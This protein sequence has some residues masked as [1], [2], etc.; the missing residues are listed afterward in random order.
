MN[1][2][3]VEITVG[4]DGSPSAHRALTWAVE[5]AVR[6]HL[7]VHIVT[8]W[9]L[10]IVYAGFSSAVAVPMSVPLVRAHGEAAVARALQEAHAAGA[11]ARSTFCE[12]DAGATLVRLSAGADQVVV[13]DRGQSPV[14]RSLM[15]S[16]SSYVAHHSDVPVTVV[17]GDTRDR[18]PVIVGVDP[19]SPSPPAI[20]RAAIEAAMSEAE[21]LVIAT[22]TFADSGRVG[23]LLGTEE[24]TGEGIERAVREQVS[25]LITDVISTLGP[26]RTRLDVAQGA[27]RKVLVRA[28][29]GADLLVVGTR[30]LGAVGRLCLGSTSTSCL[31]H[32]ACPVQVVP[33]TGH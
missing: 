30:R 32:A 33:P 11:Q 18:R 28:S 17:R 29:A 27:A 15:G 2:E 12:A 5:R 14:G 21:L 10:P 19:F 3:P 31:H 1:A 23:R 22:W 20:R 26:I 7:R 6:R 4:Y 25:G 16:V 24:P 8:T 9:Q 13:G